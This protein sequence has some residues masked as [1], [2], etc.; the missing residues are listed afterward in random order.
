MAGSGATWLEA[1]LMAPSV[2]NSTCSVPTGSRILAGGCRACLLGSV[3]FPRI[4]RALLELG[5]VPH[6]VSSCLLLASEGAE[7]HLAWQMAA[8]GPQAPRE[9]LAPALLR[10]R[11]TTSLG[12]TKLPP[13]DG[14]SMWSSCHRGQGPRRV[15][16]GH[17]PRG[18]QVS[19]QREPPKGAGQGQEGSSCVSL[20][21]AAARLT[22]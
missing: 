22:S 17:R 7:S 11:G 14:S 20:A 21:R 12:T 4:R 16:G 19:A 10:G 2:L 9:H 18:T 3:M 1:V 6:S 8:R 13:L 15:W 5:S